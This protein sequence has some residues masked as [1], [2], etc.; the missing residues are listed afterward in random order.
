M[1]VS[2]PSGLK[3]SS[4]EKSSS[5]MA[6]E[7]SFVSKKLESSSSIDIQESSKT[8][9]MSSLK[10]EV[11]MSKSETKSLTKSESISSEISEE[12]VRF[13]KFHFI[14]INFLGPVTN[15]IYLLENSNK[16]YFFPNSFSP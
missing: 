8:M 7:D 11:S 14:K 16:K 13:E 9:S 2:S 10:E 15:R 12:K 4:M 6:S 1:L 3:M 5:V